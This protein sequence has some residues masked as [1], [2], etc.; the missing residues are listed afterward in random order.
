MTKANAATKTEAEMKASKLTREAL[1]ASGKE[2]TC[3]KH[4]KTPE[5]RC[6]DSMQAL[7]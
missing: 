3:F 5:G 7:I 1:N 4:F 2:P 6:T